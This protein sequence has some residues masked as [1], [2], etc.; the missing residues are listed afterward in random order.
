MS[1]TNPR[2]RGFTLIELIIF[3]VVVSVGLVG[4]LQVMNTVVKSSADPMVRKQAMALAES[5]LEEIMLKNYN[6]PD[7]LPNVVEPSGRTE[8]DNVDD[9]DNINETISL[10][11]PVF[12]GLPPGVYGYAVNVDVAGATLGTANP[13]TARS[14]TVRVSRGSESVT[15]VGYRACYGETNP[16]TGLSSCP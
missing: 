11:G 10:T 16:A 2:Q 9:Y 12:I 3:I 13:V 15:L 1:T 4:I 5:V 8:W 7:G 14:V 6:D